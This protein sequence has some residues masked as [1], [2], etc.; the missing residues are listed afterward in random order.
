MNILAEQ[1]SFMV[2]LTIVYSVHFIVLFS[3][4]VV[5]RNKDV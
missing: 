3:H 4:K 5:Y 2:L 1:I